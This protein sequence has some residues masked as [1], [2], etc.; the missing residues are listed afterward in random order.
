MKPRWARPLMLATAILWLVIGIDGLRRGDTGFIPI[1]ATLSG[2][3]GLIAAWL[4][5]GTA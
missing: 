1:A 3:L 4:D 2:V 5:R